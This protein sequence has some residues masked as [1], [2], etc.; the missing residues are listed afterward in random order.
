MEN[1]QAWEEDVEVSAAE[2]C[3]C[4]SECPPNRSAGL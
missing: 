1:G 3:F 2:L 4:P